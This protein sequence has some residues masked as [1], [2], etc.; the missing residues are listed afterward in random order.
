MLEGY[1]Y[2]YMFYYYFVIGFINVLVINFILYNI[3]WVIGFCI[4]VLIIWF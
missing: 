2:I 1:I 3:I 4:M